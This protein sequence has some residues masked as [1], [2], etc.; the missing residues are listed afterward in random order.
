M[1]LKRQQW[2]LFAIMLAIPI[3]MNIIG[4]YRDWHD[5]FVQAITTG[6]VTCSG[7]WVGSEYEKFICRPP[8]NPWPNILKRILVITTELGILVWF[9]LFLSNRVLTLKSTLAPWFPVTVIMALFTG[10]RFTVGSVMIAETWVYEF[11]S[12]NFLSGLIFSRTV[13]IWS[14][15]IVFPAVSVLMLY[16]LWFTQIDI[17]LKRRRVH[18]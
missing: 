6:K 1:N 18:P 16:A 3:A 17:T 7:P 5:E 14:P 15:R 9:E 2:I 13:N 4:M 10:V 8:Y 12:L 11:Y